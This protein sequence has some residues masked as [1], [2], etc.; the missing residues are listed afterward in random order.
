MPAWEYWSHNAVY[1]AVSLA[2]ILLVLFVWARFFA[3]R[4][5]RN[6]VASSTDSGLEEGSR[7]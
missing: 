5:Y 3:I 7:G 1:A 6:Y 2:L 4:A